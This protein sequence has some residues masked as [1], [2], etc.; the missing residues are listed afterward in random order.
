MTEEQ[1]DQRPGDEASLHALY[2]AVPSAEELDL[3]DALPPALPFTVFD[4]PPAEDEA[5]LSDEVGEED[6]EEDAEDEEVT[7]LTDG[8][9]R[10]VLEHLLGAEPLE[11]EPEEEDT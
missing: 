10:G 4:P 6:G 11:D 9:A 3:A 1:A 8:Q 7:P 2:A 5:D